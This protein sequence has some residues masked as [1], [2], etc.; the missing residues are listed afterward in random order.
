M[1]WST[2]YV[3]KTGSDASSD[4]SNIGT[5]YATIKKANQN[6]NQ[7]GTIYVRGG[8]YYTGV[9]A[10]PST[11]T[12]TWASL[13]SGV[14]ANNYTTIQSYAQEPV[15]FS[16]N[17]SAHTQVCEFWN[18]TFIKFQDIA[19]NGDSTTIHALRSY[20]CNDIEVVGCELY[21]SALGYLKNGFGHRIN[22]RQCTFHDMIATTNNPAYGSNAIYF[23]SGGDSSDCVI[24]KSLFYNIG[25]VPIQIQPS[26][27]PTNI[28]QFDRFIIR[29]N[30]MYNFNTYTGGSVVI[31][32]VAGY[33]SQIYYNLI[34]G[35]NTTADV[36][37]G[38]IDIAI[39]VDDATGTARGDVSVLN[40]T[41]HG[42]KGYGISFRGGTG[43]ICRNNI[44]LEHTL[45]NLYDPD[46][47]ATKSNNVTSGTA[48]DIWENPINYS[49]NTSPETRDYTPKA[50]ASTVIDQGVAVGIAFDIFGTIIPQ[51]PAPD[52]GAVE[53]AEAGIWSAGAQNP[54]G[55]WSDSTLSGYS[56]RQ[57]I[58][59]SI[60]SAN[61]TAIRVILQG[62]TDAAY[63]IT[64]MAIVER[65]GATLD[66]VDGTHTEIT[67]GDTYAAGVTVPQGGQ[68]ISDD[69]AVTID[70]TKDYFITWYAS[71]SVGV[72][73]T[74]GSTSSAW[75]VNSD[76][77]ATIDWGAQSPSPIRTH[78]YDILRIEETVAPAPAASAPT[79]GSPGV[80]I[81]EPGTP[82][83][84][85]I[86]LVDQD[87]DITSSTVLSTKSPLTITQSGSATI[88]I[89]TG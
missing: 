13:P 20:N 66:G 60:I 81:V 38:M 61:A 77:A 2:I 69:I 17:N 34:Y 14:D 32:L 7:G 19:F 25:R 9:I 15:I 18:K 59:G 5:P 1:A 79:V 84:L 68:A 54:G 24:E 16:V 57:L 76:I 70:E 44:A 42:S 33:Q 48:A 64:K 56:V 29:Y 47:R 26:G 27:G 73:F 22:I 11:G 28:H 63:T 65:D 39:K 83:N 30:T 86:V 52:V 85:S 41:V 21:N 45:G 35:Q 72:Y 37:N 71:A 8:T 89:Y 55:A 58:K 12:G 23:G 36:F 80:V 43:H 62:R 31:Y 87:Y 4:P 67:F 6:L 51:G 53:R 74:G 46:S 10:D 88:D 40:N 82:K 75:L 50:A 78:V 3:S 49:T